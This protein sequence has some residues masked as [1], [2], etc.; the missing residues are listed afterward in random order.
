VARLGGDEF[1][2]L[3]PEVGNAAAA[4]AVGHKLLHAVAEEVSVGGRA[5]SVTGS[6]GIAMFADAAQTADQ[7]L[8]AADSAMY[9]AKDLGGARVCLH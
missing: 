1:V 4:I 8:A 7:L 3:L 6:I 9:A 2:V 5:L